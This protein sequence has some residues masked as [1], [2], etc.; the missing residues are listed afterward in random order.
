MSYLIRN[1][2]LDDVSRLGELLD[3]FMQETFQKQWG[4]NIQQLQQDSF[5]REF[6]II[7]A[8]SSQEIIA[9]LA[10]ISSYDLH[11]CIKG[12]E[13]IDLFVCPAHRNRGVATLLIAAVAVEIEKAGGKYIKGQAVNNPAAQRLYQRCARCF[14]GADCYVSGRAF[15]RLV[16]LSG[17]SLRSIVNNLPQSAWNYEP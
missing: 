17:Q 5:G 2:I 11:H 14:P 8:E 6:Q 12:G 10:W 16:E 1:A 9:F 13:I 3:A 4:G 7:V 15:R